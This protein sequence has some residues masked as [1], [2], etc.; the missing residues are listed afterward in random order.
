MSKRRA[1]SSSITSPRMTRSS[2]GILSARLIQE[3][4]RNLAVDI[5]VR[6]DLIFRARLGETG[7]GNDPL[8]WPE[9]AAAAALL[10]EAS[11]LR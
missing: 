10:G 8:A 6:G 3:L 5:V 11:L 9:Q 1:E 4:G 2:L 7:P